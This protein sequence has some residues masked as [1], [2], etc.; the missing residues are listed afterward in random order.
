M[1]FRKKYENPWCDRLP[2]ETS[3]A[4]EEANVLWAPLPTTGFALVRFTN[5]WKKDYLV[6]LR[7]VALGFKMCFICYSGYKDS[8]ICSLEFLKT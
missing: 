4:L 1:E 2:H 5:Q 7:E 6:S 3:V 8:F